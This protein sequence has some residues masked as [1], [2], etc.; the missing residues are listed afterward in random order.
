MEQSRNN[1]IN[2]VK[3]PTYA[4][5]TGTTRVVE[6]NIVLTVDIIV[7]KFEFISINLDFFIL[8]INSLFWGISNTVYLILSIYL[9]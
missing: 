2:P 7:L 6:P 9:I 8:M 1:T 3:I 4:K 5:I